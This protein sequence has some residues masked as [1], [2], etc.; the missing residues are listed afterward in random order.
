MK[1]IQN[2]LVMVFFVT[3]SEHAFGQRHIKGLMALEAQFG[4]MNNLSVFSKDSGG[5]HVSMGLSKYINS[6]S[7]WKLHYD[8]DRRNYLVLD[9]PAFT[10]RQTGSISYYRTILK[11][12]E[13]NFYLN[14]HVGGL[15]GYENINNNE[16][17]ISGVELKARSKF[18]YGLSAGIESEVF[19]SDHLALLLQ[20]RERLF[21]PSDTEKLRWYAGAG[22]KWMLNR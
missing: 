20:F 22:L 13:G 18:V 14:V 3:I 9:A 17:V 7:Y 4:F 11:D 8:A 5:H 2:I 19:L 15:A 1:T 6:N 12:K 10:S 16:R 21:I